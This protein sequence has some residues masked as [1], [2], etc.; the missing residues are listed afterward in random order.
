MANNV[1]KLFIDMNSFYSSIEQQ[2]NNKYR[3][4]PTI[5][6]PI[7]TDYTCAIA[8]SYEAK[9][10]GIK[11]GMSVL[12]AVRKYP[13]LNV[14]EARPLE[15]VKMHTKLVRVLKRH[16]YNVK[17]LSIDE[18]S[19]DI[20][21]MSD[22]DYFK[23]S[24][25][26]KADIFKELGEC[27]SCSIGVSDNT[28]LAKVASDFQKPNGFTIV[29]SYEDLYNLKLTDLPGIN[30]R[31]QKRLNSSSIY[32]VKDLCSLNELELKKAWGSVVGA[33]WYYMLRGN[34]DCD[35]G[36]H[37]K[38][39]PTSVGHAHVLP[40]NMKSME[41]AYT[42]F[43]ALICRGLNRLTEYRLCASKLD[44]FLSWKNKP[45]KGCY[46]F[47]TPI[48]TSSSNHGYW[49]NQAVELWKKIP[50]EIQGKPFS[51]GIRFTH[52]IPEKDLNLSLFDI[53]LE[54]FNMQK[55]YMLPER[56]SFGNPD[57]MFN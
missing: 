30:T 24:A 45:S 29:K 46:K 11:S 33:R 43:E 51:V 5:V 26:L 34:Q 18:M 54:T 20:E 57:R 44:I 37:Y 23:I 39:I 31:M 40:P 17:V 27:M 10:H 28:F 16:F 25:A 3:K 22:T 9:A 49:M 35:Y 19:C 2:E 50:Y 8:A 32:T 7:L 41:G 38:D 6:V 14:V 55:K 1:R 36:M 48:V 52:T 15:Y 53:P 21:N 42:I 12:D 13:L 4:Q 56:I 47:S